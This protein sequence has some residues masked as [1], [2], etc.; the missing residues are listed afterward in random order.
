MI[1]NVCTGD[2]ERKHHLYFFP[3]TFKIIMIHERVTKANHCSEVDTLK[4]CSQ[5]RYRENTVGLK[6]QSE[7]CTEA[8]SETA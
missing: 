8:L 5:S 6:R 2:A 4:K 7:L 1:Y 3:C